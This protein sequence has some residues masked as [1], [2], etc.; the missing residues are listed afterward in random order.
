M[1]L[2]CI[3]TRTLQ[4]ACRGGWWSLRTRNP[5][6]SILDLLLSSA[7]SLT[8]SV[9]LSLAARL[10]VWN[11]I[12]LCGYFCLLFFFFSDSNGCVHVCT[13]PKIQKVDFDFDVD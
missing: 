2:A 8:R 1:C 13:Y 7:L 10:P 6:R 3:P 11:L 5:C 12:C 9:V 4:G